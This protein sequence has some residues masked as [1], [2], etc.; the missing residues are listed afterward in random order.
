[1]ESS[2]YLSNNYDDNTYNLIYNCVNKC[3]CYTHAKQTHSSL[4][5]HISAFEYTQSII[6]SM[7]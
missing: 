1:M 2:P 4:T 6:Y 7:F 3:R 5:P